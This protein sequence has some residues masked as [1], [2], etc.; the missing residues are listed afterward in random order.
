[1][2]VI[3]LC[4]CGAFSVAVRERVAGWI[5]GDGV[6]EMAAGAAIGGWDGIVF[7]K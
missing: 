4:G 3:W 5:E 6:G 7:P 2:D 1:M